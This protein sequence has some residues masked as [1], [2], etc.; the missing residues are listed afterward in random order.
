M[1]LAANLFEMA[2][3][4]VTGDLEGIYERDCNYITVGGKGRIRDEL[5]PPVPT[6][7]LRHVL[8][9]VKDR[10]DGFQQLVQAERLI[11]N[12]ICGYSGLPRFDDGMPR[13][14]PKSGHQD[15]WNWVNH[16]F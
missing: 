15:Q 11:Q 2:V 10:L 12:G 8:R 1:Q 3:G 6:L 16:V 5:E 4:H 14:I 7:C 9:L 13:V